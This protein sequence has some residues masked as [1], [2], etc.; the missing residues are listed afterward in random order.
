[1]NNTTKIKT[2][3]APSPTGFLHIGN[4]RTAI[5]CYLFT[6]K[7]NGEF[8]LRFDDTD[9][10][11]SREE[12]KT[13]ILEDL[14]WLGFEINEQFKQTDRLELYKQKRDELI[15]KGKVYP[16]Y[17]TA[18]ELNLQRKSQAARGVP[19]I[20]D[21]SALNLTEE[22]VKAY[23]AEGRKPYY[24]FLLGDEPI[25]WED[26]TKGSIRYNERVF[27][28]PVIYRANGM[29]TYVFCSVVDDVEMGIT[30]IVRGEDHVTNT[31]VQTQIFKALGDKLPKFYHT[32]LFKSK[33]GKISK[34][35]GGFEVKALREAGIES[36]ALWNLVIKLGASSD[37]AL[38]KTMDELIESFDLEGYGKA[39]VNYAYADLERLNARYVKT[40]SHKEALPRLKEM[41]LDYIDEDFWSSVSQNLNKI[42]EIK[43]WWQICKEEVKI[44]L[45]EEDR[46]FLRKTVA[47][48]P[49]KELNDEFYK[50]WIDLI[51]TETGRKGKLLFMPI[52]LA[53]TGQ[54]HG[55]DLKS[56]LPLIGREEIIKRL[57]S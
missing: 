12:Y 43:E 32:S 8:I 16:C 10:E 57:Q 23:E 7:H 48:L 4:L 54:E 38:Y 35:I 33:E 5:A 2:R 41:K 50:E 27:S 6:K 13:S 42:S 40:L 31:A 1:M 11:R 14:N 47:L 18:E 46:D 19:P 26:G 51:K 15:A 52:R 25:M 56:M 17:E 34:R 3:F 20:Y 9:A 39:A 29:P 24:R 37:N 36:M 22:Q 45:N 55:P 30:H 44:E 53:L 28:D 49:E 21:R